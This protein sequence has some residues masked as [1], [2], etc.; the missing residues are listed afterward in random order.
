MTRPVLI[1][2]VD[3]AGRGPLAGDVFAAAVIL[4]SGRAIKGLADSKTL[5]AKRR[6]ALDLEIRERAL[7]YCVATA[8]VA[9][10]D[11]VNILQASLLAMA[12]AVEGLAV[13]PDEMWVDGLYLPNITLP[14][15]AIVAGD[16][17]VES[18][19]AASILAKTARDK[20]LQRVDGLYPG[21]GFAHHKGYGTRA[22][23]EALAR[24][25][26]CPLHRMSFAPV[27]AAAHAIQLKPLP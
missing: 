12:R 23:K 10:I 20:E 19:S 4:D 7:A 5:S 22:H 1:C 9:E 24:L 26:P 15:R 2:G 13:R 8:S 21:Y 3:E 18:I 27:R 6:V 25:G 17:L 14:G 11:R 16:R